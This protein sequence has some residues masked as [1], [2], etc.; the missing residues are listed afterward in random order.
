MSADET[1]LKKEDTLAKV[2]LLLSALL[3]VAFVAL[4][5]VGAL[6]IA[7][8][9]GS[10]QETDNEE[11]PLLLTEEETLTSDGLTISQADLD[12]LLETAVEEGYARGLTDGVADLLSGIAESFAAGKSTVQTLRPYYT[13]KI[14]LASGGKVCF[15]DILDSLE[16][17][18]YTAD[19]LFVTEDGEYQYYE[20]D[21]LISYKGIDVSKFQ[22]DI[23]WEKVAADG[24][25]FAFV[26][27]GYRGY[28]SGALVEDAYF[29][30]NVEG[31]QAAGIA[32]GVYFYTQAIT[33]EEALEEAAMVLELIA[34]YD[35]ECPVVFDVEYVSGSSARMNSLTA[36]ER[37]AVTLAFCEAIKA[38]GV[39]VMIYHNMEVGAVLL[40]LTQLTDYAKWL[41]YYSDDFYYPYAFTI[42]QYSE[43]GSVSGISGDVDM[44][45]SFSKFW[46]E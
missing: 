14:V 20:N 30:Q 33:V 6:Y 17:H 3:A 1:L 32:V 31:A 28:G 29:A 39:E 35:L 45:I 11:D 37:T 16:K 22:G 19:N 26:R 36:E 8:L 10:L 13:D 2:I 21:A 25:A 18:T 15:V 40:D 41:A 44:N 42:W 5:L 27:A 34:P 43:S 24:V 46:E 23:D 12:A 7:A 9:R 4:L 38:A